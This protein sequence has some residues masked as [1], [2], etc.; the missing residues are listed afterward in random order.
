MGIF[1]VLGGGGS[2]NRL[3]MKT[4]E[5]EEKINWKDF[6][7]NNKIVVLAVDKNRMRKLVKF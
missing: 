6:E 1:A 3:T 5:L 4:E 2:D 7:V